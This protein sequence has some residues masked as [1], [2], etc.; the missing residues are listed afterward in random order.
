MHS[1]VSHMLVIITVKNEYLQG[2]SLS[3]MMSLRI[4]MTAEKHKN[5]ETSITAANI[6]VAVALF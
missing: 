3:S 1:T 2:L 5:D 6:I 4:F